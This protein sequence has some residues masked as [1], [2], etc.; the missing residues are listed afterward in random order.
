MLRSLSD[1]GGGQYYHMEDGDAVASSFGDCIGGLLSVVGQ[2]VRLTLQAAGADIT[3]MLSQGYK[4]STDVEAGTTTV[5][6]GDIYSEEFKD[7]VFEVALP[8]GEA[9]A[10]VTAKLTYLDVVRAEIVP[11]IETKVA[12]AR[13]DETASE[14]DLQ[15]TEQ[16]NRIETVATIK[17]ANELARKGR[18]AEG[19]KMLEEAMDRLK[20]SPAAQNSA[21]TAKL[22]ADLAE[23]KCGMRDQESFRTSG[24]NFCQS[25]M[26]SH[27][28][29]RMNR[30]TPKRSVD[31]GK[32]AWSTDS[33]YDTNSK[34]SMRCKWT[35][36]ADPAPTSAPMV[37]QTHPKAGGAAAERAP[38]AKAPTPFSEKALAQ[39]MQ[40]QELQLA[41]CHMPPPTP[42]KQEVAGAAVEEATPPSSMSNSSG[43]DGFVVVDAAQEY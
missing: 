43:S 36:S 13:A 9:T 7:I 10:Q 15:I 42:M 31:S 22:V 21:L 19:A 20:L 37:L 4:S 27:T 11:G 30:C 41:Q 24:S 26:Q 25:S 17:Q 40:S 33:P 8:E 38:Q 16:V 1:A 39:L 3:K 35:P 23:C 18:Y 34:R 6:L 5:C 14:L 32:E 28:R 2:N 12:I 29:Q